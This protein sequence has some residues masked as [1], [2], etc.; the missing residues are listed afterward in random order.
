MYRYCVRE[1]YAAVILDN[2]QVPR[3][4]PVYWGGSIIL[5]LRSISCV[6]INIRRDCN[7]SPVCTDVL[8][9]QVRFVCV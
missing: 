3:E 9:L 6:L 7:G 2:K 4:R 5:S 1:N 8:L